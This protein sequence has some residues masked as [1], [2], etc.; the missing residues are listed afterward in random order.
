MPDH[1]SPEFRSW[2]MRRIRSRNTQPELIVRSFIHKQGFRFRLHDGRLPGKP[3]VVLRRLRTIIFVNGCF[4]HQHSGCKRATMPRSN[5]RYWKMKLAKNIERLDNSKQ[6]LQEAGWKIIE[7]W[8][9][10]AKSQEIL[11]KKLA[12]LFALRKK[13]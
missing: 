3:D 2:N 9:C 6:R 7:V 10:E 4:W 11:K 12:K 5:R 8:E 1:L 13:K